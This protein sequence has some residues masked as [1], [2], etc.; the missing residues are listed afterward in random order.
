MFSKKNL[1]VK[2]LTLTKT[3]TNEID[4]FEQSHYN[5]QLP[6]TILNRIHFEYVKQ[7]IYVLFDVSALKP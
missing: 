6:S 4:M 1:K 5:V 3:T 2:C 7:D